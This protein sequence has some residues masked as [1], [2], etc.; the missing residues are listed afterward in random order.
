MSPHPLV[1]VP[2]KQEQQGDFV[3]EWVG[4][5]S[6]R[7]CMLLS[8]WADDTGDGRKGLLAGNYRQG[9]LALHSIMLAHELPL[10]VLG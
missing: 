7:A 4:G 2:V 3:A 10:Q 1:P 9:F 5:D 6:Q 8:C